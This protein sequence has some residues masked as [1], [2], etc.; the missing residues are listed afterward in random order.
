M[1]TTACC[2]CS[3]IRGQA[4]GDLIA[5]LL[6]DQPYAR[7]VLLE[8]DKFAAIP[9]LGPLVPGHS[10]LCPKVHTPS[11]ASLDPLAREDLEHARDDL[12]TRLSRLYGGEVHI[13]RFSHQD[14]PSMDGQERHLCRSAA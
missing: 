12:S 3:Q 10:L 5:C 13:L 4:D 9:S 11:F 14:S 2:I 7:R 6:P 1:E 8:T